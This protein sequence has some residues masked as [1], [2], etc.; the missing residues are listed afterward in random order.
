MLYYLQIAL[1][2][3]NVDEC[4]PCHSNSFY[5]KAILIKT[6]RT[7]GIA[8]AIVAENAE[9][10]MA[11]PAKGKASFSCTMAA[12]PN[13]CAAAPTDSPR[14]TGSRIPTRFNTFAPK[15]APNSP[16][17]TT[18][19]TANETSAC[20]IPAI[21]MASGDVI[22]RD[23]KLNRTAA[24]ECV[25]HRTAPAVPNKPD[26]VDT[27]MAVTMD[28]QLSRINRRRAYML[29][30]KLTTAGPKHANKR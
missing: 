19:D 15:L 7:T 28:R 24:L 2:V 23:N 10:A 6:F 5:P 14:A 11:A 1:S 29:Q 13:P 18:M 30:A 8:T 25:N 26:T 9:S 16:V 21:A 12:V 3:S 22:F 4:K 17:T 20:N 27:V